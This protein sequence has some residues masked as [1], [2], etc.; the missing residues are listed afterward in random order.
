MIAVTGTQ[1]ASA[2]SVGDA[3]ALDVTIQQ[4]K[5]EALE[6][7]TG[8]QR[9]EDTLKYPVATRLTID[10]SVVQPQLLIQAITVTIDNLPPVHREYSQSTARVLT[11]SGL[12]RLLRTNV[13]PG[14]HR[15]HAEFTAANTTGGK[16]D[17][18]PLTG[19]LD[20]A[21]SKDNHPVVLELALGKGATAT[22]AL[23]LHSWSVQP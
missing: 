9:A 22:P 14:Q 8:T 19:S 10:L 2:D 13:A 5:Q 15:L 17:A 16:T 21:F 11:K 3:A 6:I 1:S 12:D 4:L 20:Q 18:Q 23:S 7:G